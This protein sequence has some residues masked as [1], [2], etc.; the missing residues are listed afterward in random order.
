MARETPDAL[1]A[2]EDYWAMG[3]D[4]SL[5][6]LAALYRSR[7]ESGEPVPTV[8]LGTIKGWSSDHDWQARVAAR[9]AEEAE[10]TRKRHW[11]RVEKQ[12]QRYLL[13]IEAGTVKFQ[14]GLASGEVVLIENA[15][16]LVATGKFYFQVAGEPLADRQELTGVDGGPVQTQA[17]TIHRLVLTDEAATAVVRFMTEQEA[18]Q[19][20]DGAGGDGHGDGDG[21]AD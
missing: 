17:A 1:Q 21:Q 4:R 14:Q 13:G 11:E 9:I 10:L 8:R 19:Q 5:P 3:G 16:D 7:T 20:E 6:K 15:A 12:R 18:A 2:F